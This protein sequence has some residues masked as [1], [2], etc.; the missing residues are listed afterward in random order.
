MDV[1]YKQ[2]TTFPKKIDLK[3]QWVLVDASN[4]IAGRLA[5][6]VTYRLLG[7]YRPDYT[8]GAL[9]GDSVI[10]INASKVKF[11]GSKMNQKE[12]IRHTGFIGGL[13]RKLLKDVPKDKALFYAIKGMLPKTK[14]GNKLLKRLRI[15][16]GE[17]H[18]LKAQK[19]K[20]IT[21]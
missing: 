11:T 2:K 18:P 3:N 7:K 20:F 13:K 14:Y 9:L 8:P 1:L 5:S 21:L 6:K 19:P 10:I 12:Y 17:E 4:Q 16:L 15:V